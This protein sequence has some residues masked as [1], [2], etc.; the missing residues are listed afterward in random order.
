[1]KIFLLAGKARSGKGEVAKSIRKIYDQQGQKTVI[2]EFSKYLKL[3]AREMTDW[4]GSEETKPRRFLQDMGTFIRKNLKNPDFLIDRMKEDIKIYQKFFDN[5]VISDVRFPTEIEKIK[6]NYPEVYAIYIISEH[7]DYDLSIEEA[8]H[9][10]EHALDQ[11]NDF[12]FMVVNDDKMLLD[13]KMKEIL[14]E[15]E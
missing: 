15:L 7:G 5:I 3:L 9:E 10:T 13:Q 4:N 14:G 6:Q 8:N 1:M 11:Y 2:T 12:D